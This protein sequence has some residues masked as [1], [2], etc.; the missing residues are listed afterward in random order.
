MSSIAHCKSGYALGLLGKYDEA[1]RCYQRAIDIDEK[2]AEAYNL[3][4]ATFKHL[5]WME[6]GE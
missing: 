5:G 4:G 6:K 3:M 1:I 2:N